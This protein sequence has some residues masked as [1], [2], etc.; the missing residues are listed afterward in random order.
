M[1]IICAIISVTLV[2]HT[3]TYLTLDQSA[4]RMLNIAITKYAA[5][6]IV[7]GDRVN[8]HARADSVLSAF[9][10]KVNR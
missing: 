3:T 10:G 1:L 7:M 4:L 9:G 2:L 8:G 5:T 6:P